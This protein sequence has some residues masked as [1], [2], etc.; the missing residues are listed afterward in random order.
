MLS[1]SDYTIGSDLL[2]NEDDD[3]IWLK[4]FIGYIQNFKIRKL[5][6]Y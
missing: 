5:M 3:T 1:L 4:E 6:S 2:I